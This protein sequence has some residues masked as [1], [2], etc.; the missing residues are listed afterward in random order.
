MVEAG[1]RGVSGFRLRTTRPDSVSMMTKLTALVGSRSEAMICV[2]GAG[3]PTPSA[4]H[5]QAGAQHIRASAA[6]FNE[7]NLHAL[8]RHAS[9]ASGSDMRWHAPDRQRRKSIDPR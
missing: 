9:Q 6:R 3:A 2:T 1:L 8:H 7:F 5:A 4:A